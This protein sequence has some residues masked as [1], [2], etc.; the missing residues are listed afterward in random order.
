VLLLLCAEKARAF[1]GKSYKRA[2]FFLNAYLSEKKKKEKKEGGNRARS[3]RGAEFLEEKT[4]RK[5]KGSKKGSIHAR[6]INPPAGEK[7]KEK[8]RLCELKGEHLS[9]NNTGK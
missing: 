2:S 1:A 8:K 3:A 5:R 6:A 9:H 4:R 7:K